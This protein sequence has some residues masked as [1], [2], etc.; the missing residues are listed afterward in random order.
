MYTNKCH[1]YDYYGTI[2]TIKTRLVNVK[3]LKEDFYD[4]F[5]LCSQYPSE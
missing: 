2:I 4:I 5:R 1:Y 3:F